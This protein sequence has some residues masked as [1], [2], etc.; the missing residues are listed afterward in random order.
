MPL[1]VKKHLILLER[2]KNPGEHR[3]DYMRL[4]KNENVAGLPARLVGILKKEI[5]P[6]FVT[7]YPELQPLYRKIAKWVGLGAE[8]IYI[9]A[10]SDGAIKS[11]FEVFVA[12][13]DAIVLINP[14]YAMFDVYAKMFQSRVI[15][16]QYSKDLTISA[17]E[18]LKA[19]EKEKPKLVCIANPNSPT[20][21]IISR[22][23]IRQIIKVAGRS[24]CMVL[25]DEAYHPF[26]RVSSVPL[27]MRYSNVIVTR[28]FS[29]AFGL[30]AARIG[31]ACAHPDTA[32]YLHKVRPM[33]ETNSFAVRFA[34]IMID[35]YDVVKAYVAKVRQAKSFMEKRLSEK[36]IPYAKSYA[37]F[38]L[39][40]AGSRQESIR[41]Q[42][43]LKKRAIL[44]QGGFSHPALDRYI[45]VTIGT[46]SQMKLFLK[47][48]LEISTGMVRRKTRSR[49]HIKKRRIL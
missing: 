2:I 8:S 29:K 17:R 33:Y 37:N 1:P 3:L 18:I 42:E 15:K 26:Y 35:H 24:G 5:T 21:T 31:F 12:P 36:G 46:I 34:E 19:I 6:A 38:I 47:I 44:I 39:I 13:G 20:G 40:D 4:D 10:G 11:V 27:V 9:A 32:Y 30:A 7:A 25:M 28:S 45:R 16:I 49:Q 41:I 14:T 43:A 48:F 22:R 23:E